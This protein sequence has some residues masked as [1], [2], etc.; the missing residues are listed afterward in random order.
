M[1]YKSVRQSLAKC[2]RAK[3]QW[4]CRLVLAEHISESLTPRLGGVDPNL[5][6][7]IKGTT[8]GIDLDPATIRLKPRVMDDYRWEIRSNCVTKLFQTS[9][10]RLSKKSCIAICDGVGS[11]FIAVCRLPTSLQGCGSAGYTL[12]HGSDVLNYQS[13]EMSNLHNRM[14]QL[15]KVV[16]SLL[17]KLDQIPIERR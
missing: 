13:T 9:V 2:S 12:A 15:G 8:L 14:H 16:E 11:H 1:H 7:P 6:T 5:D 17:S 10:G 3:W 4:I